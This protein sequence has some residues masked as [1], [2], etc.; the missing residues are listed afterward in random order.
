MQSPNPSKPA[1]VHAWLRN[2]IIGLVA[3]F[4]ALSGTAVAAQVVTKSGATTAKAKKGPRGPAGP[5]G[6][7]GASGAAGAAGAQ[8]AQGVPGTAKAFTY[9]LGAAAGVAGS[10]QVDETKSFGITD[11]NVDQVTTGIF[12]FHGLGFTPKAISVVPGLTGSGAPMPLV[13]ADAFFNS[14]CAPGT[15]AIIEVFTDLT[16]GT[17][18]SKPLSVVIN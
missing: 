18:V 16:Q 2:N 14:D 13:K 10:D 1:P 3:I 12:C 5:A 4:I 17:K 15:Q 6:P 7:A 9:I 11:A 8:G